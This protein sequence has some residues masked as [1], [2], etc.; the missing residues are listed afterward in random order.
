[1]GHGDEFEAL[2]DGHYADVLA[3]AIRRCASRQD[4]EDVVAET[5]AV[6][7]RRRGELPPGAEARLWL[8]GT[9][10]LVV[11]NV[12]RG[13][14]RHQRLSERLRRRVPPARHRDPDVDAHDR[15]REALAALS[16]NDREVLR[17]HAWEALSADEIATTLNITT[18]AA[19]KR[20][21]RARE[22]LAAALE[23]DHPRRPA[24]TVAVEPS[25]KAA[26]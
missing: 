7:W 9:A 24:S 22:R 4:A 20:L 21:Q 8:F 26:R 13:R 17:L 25:R 5:F 3:Y 6:A 12:E 23:R 14:V 1:M 10:R 2:F 16:E 15:L 19:W 18:P 11:Q